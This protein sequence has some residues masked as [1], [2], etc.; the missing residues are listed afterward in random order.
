M[1]ALLGE[2]PTELEHLTAGLNDTTKAA[3]DLTKATETAEEAEKRFFGSVD[4]GLDNTIQNYMDKLKFLTAGGGELAKLTEH[5]AAALVAGKITEPQ[6]NEMFGE[7]FVA[8]EALKV[9]IGQI[10]ADQAA[11]NIASTLGISLDEAVAKIALIKGIDGA[12]LEAYLNL[13][14]TENYT[15]D[16][17]K[18]K[19]VPQYAS[20]GRP[21]PGEPAMIGEEGPEIFVPDTPG[22]I[23]PNRQIKNMGPTI[24]NNYNYN[25]HT[26]AGASSL[27]SYGKLKKGRA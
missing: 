13:T 26:T 1:I 7:A 19:P 24:T 2:A 8:V 15:P 14:I 18:A 17:K 23:I 20:G 21:T 4:T 27:L 3:D 10:T 16:P 5:I 25:I 11:Q 6:A 22:T 9:N 12:K